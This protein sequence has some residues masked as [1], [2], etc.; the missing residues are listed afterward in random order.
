MN[1]MRWPCGLDQTLQFSKISIRLHAPFNANPRTFFSV[2]EGMNFVEPGI[3]FEELTY[4]LIMSLDRCHFSFLG[5][6]PN[7]FRLAAV[8]AEAH[9]RPAC[10]L[11]YAPRSI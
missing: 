8:R 6:V 10:V 7:C 2:H 4:S 5:L 1:R 3:L 9:S 11:D